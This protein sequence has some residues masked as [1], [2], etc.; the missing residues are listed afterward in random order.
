MKY[1]SIFLVLMILA[2]IGGAAWYGLAPGNYKVPVTVQTIRGAGLQSST[3][4][5]NTLSCNLTVGK[6]AAEIAIAGKDPSPDVPRVVGVAPGS[7]ITGNVLI[8]GTDFY[9]N[10]IS[11]K[12][13]WVS[14]DL[15][16]YTT[17]AFSAVTSFNCT[18][19]AANSFNL[20]YGQALGLNTPLASNTRVIMATLNGVKETT[21]PTVT[22][23]S[24]VI[25]LNTIDLSS[26]LD[27]NT[28]T[29][30]FY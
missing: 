20:G 1:L 14:S 10:V 15:G 17:K 4:I 23:S 27:G 26:A 24:T 16:K 5:W 29:V 25:S 9:G 21:A 30:W 7:A 3:D 13:T 12:L 2:G 22:A 28:I 18:T 19:G 11:E 8:N 6:T